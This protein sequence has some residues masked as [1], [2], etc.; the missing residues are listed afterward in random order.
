M[1]EMRGRRWEMQFTLQDPDSGRCLFFFWSRLISKL[2]SRNDHINRAFQT[3]WRS[4]IHLDTERMSPARVAVMERRWNIRRSFRKAPE[5]WTWTGTGTQAPSVP[6]GQISSEVQQ[7]DSGRSKPDQNRASSWASRLV[8]SLKTRSILI[9]LSMSSSGVK[10]AVLPQLHKTLR[11]YVRVVVH[12]GSTWRVVAGTVLNYTDPI[13]FH[14]EKLMGRVLCCLF[15][16]LTHVYV[17][18][19]KM[20]GNF[21][22]TEVVLTICETL[23]MLFEVKVFWFHHRS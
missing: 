1:R 21:H 22:Q 14:S 8:W 19:I 15:R 2:M 6:L 11:G 5:V 20:E 23:F 12:T 13:V 18:V 16:S 7:R 9:L 17:F 3:R 4:E 10:A